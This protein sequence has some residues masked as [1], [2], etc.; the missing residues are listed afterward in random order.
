MIGMLTADKVTVNQKSSGQPGLLARPI[1]D[2]LH[3]FS[4]FEK[5]ETILDQKKKRKKEKKK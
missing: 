1:K 5:I 4:Y 2:G 3:Q